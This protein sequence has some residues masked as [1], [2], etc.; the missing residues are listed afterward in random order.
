MNVSEILDELSDHGFG[1]TGQ[2]RK[3]SFIQ[4]TIWD[5][6]GR[7]P[8]PFLEAAATNLTFSGSSGVPTNM[9]ANFR[10]VT[11][12]RDTTTGKFLHWIRDDEFEQIIGTA[13]T[14]VGSPCYYYFSG[15]ALNLYPLP[16]A[17]RTVKLKY[18]Q[19]SSAIS[20]TTLEA[21]IL[22]P[23]QF[24]RAIVWGALWKLYEM[25]DDPDTADK[26]LG[27]YE[28]ALDKMRNAVWQR[29]FTRSDSIQMIDEGYYT[30]PD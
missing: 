17:S 15:N 14:Q 20:D 28:N 9:P 8:W 12:L 13:D 22:I 26:Y 1:D 23:K 10:A 4:E 24:H 19:W 6:E 2:T 3:V 5:I 16:D 29:Q 30:W 21:A 18:L 27:H 11:S 25:E 7:E